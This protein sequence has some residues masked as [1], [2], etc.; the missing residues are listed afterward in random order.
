MSEPKFEEGLKRVRQGATLLHEKGMSLESVLTYVRETYRYDEFRNSGDKAV[1]NYRERQIGRVLWY[2][3]RLRV[4]RIGKDGRVYFVGLA[5]ANCD[6]NVLFEGET[7]TF[8]VRPSTIEGKLPSAV[9]I[10]AAA[11]ERR[12]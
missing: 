12:T 9:D 4:G 2:D 1:M 8:T 3:A 7:V 5:S 10:R 11:K 6:E